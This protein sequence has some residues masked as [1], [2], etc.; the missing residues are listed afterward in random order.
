MSEAVESQVFKEKG[1]R[2]NFAECKQAFISDGITGGARWGAVGVVS[3]LGIPT[4][5]PKSF[6]WFNWRGRV[7]CTASSFIAGFVTRGEQAL[8]NCRQQQMTLSYVKKNS[9]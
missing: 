3:F 4:L 2:A 9:L 8:Y 6:L 5:F 1:A 7:F